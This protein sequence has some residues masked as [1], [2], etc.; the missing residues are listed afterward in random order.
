MKKVIVSSLV[1]ALALNMSAAKAEDNRTEEHVG[2]GSGLVI[3]AIAGGPIGAIIGA[4]GGVW[5]GDK[6]N[7]AQQVPVLETNLNSQA[8]Q[9]D[10]LRRDLKV[11]DEELVAA[12][13]ALYNQ[14]LVQEK[15]SQQKSAVSGLKF[16][17]MFRT[18]SS[19]LEQKAVEKLLPVAMMLEQYPTLSVQITGHGDIL[20]TVD[21][22]QVVAEDRAIRVRQ[23]LINAG[24]DGNRIQIMNLGKTMASADLNDVEGRALERRVRLQFV[25]ATSADKPT[26][27]QK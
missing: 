5:L 12:R 26:L 22:N 23:S 25:E 17:L 3:G 21:A 4:A 6:V 19:E 14:E 7:T 11:T 13:Q 10:K 2:L 20:G 16:D 9:I 18:N 1:L 8:M 24:T 27:A 15:V